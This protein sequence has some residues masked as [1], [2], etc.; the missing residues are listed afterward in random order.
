MSHM[1][2]EPAAAVGRSFGVLFVLLVS[3]IAR[4]SVK[5]SSP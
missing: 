1:P 2:G 4:V 5:V 3:R